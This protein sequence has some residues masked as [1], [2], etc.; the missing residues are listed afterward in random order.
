MPV[1]KSGPLFQDP[2]VDAVRHWLRRYNVAS[3]EVPQHTPGRA[4][5]TACGHQVPT[6]APAN[7]QCANEAA[8]MMIADLPDV[9]DT[10]G[11]QKPR[12][13]RSTD[14]QITE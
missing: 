3:P 8:D 14:D 13:L 2:S 4:A 6:F 1:E 10:T 12:E 7:W 5:S 9:S 11:C